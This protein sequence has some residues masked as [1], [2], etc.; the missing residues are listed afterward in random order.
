MLNI[1][2]NLS[3]QLTKIP[4]GEKGP[5]HKNWNVTPT[6][7]ETLSSNNT[8]IGLLHSLSFTCCF[9]IDNL[10]QALKIPGFEKIIDKG[11]K[12][13]SGRPNRVK[14]LYRIPKKHDITLFR[15]WKLSYKGVDVGQF[16]CIADTGYSTQDVLPPSKHPDGYTYK[17]IDKLPLTFEEIPALPKSVIKH[18]KKMK[19]VQKTFKKRYMS[20]HLSFYVKVY[21]EWY[22]KTGKTLDDD[23]MK[24]KT[25]TDLGMG[26]YLRKGSI[27]KQSLI[28]VRDEHGQYGYNFS[29]T[30]GK[31]LLKYGGFDPYELLVLKMGGET[32]ARKFVTIDD[33]ELKQLCDASNRRVVK[34]DSGEQLHILRKEGILFDKDKGF[35]YLQLD[36]MCPG[37]TLVK[38]K[39]LFTK[40]AST[41]NFSRIVKSVLYHQ[42]GVYNPDMAFWYSLVLIDFLAG[43]G[44]ESLN[45]NRTAPLY[46]FTAGDSSDGKSATIQ[47]G[48]KHLLDV[49]G[50]GNISE[51]D[52]KYSVKDNDDKEMNPIY[53]ASFEN[54]EIIKNVGS[55]QGVEDLITIKL[56][57]GC[58]ILFTQ[59]EY[60]LSDKGTMDSAGKA[61]RSMLLSYRTLSRYEAIEPR[62]L[63]QTQAGGAQKKRHQTYCVHF[64]YFTAA[65]NETLKGVIKDS[66]VGMGYTQRFI[67]GVSRSPFFNSRRKVFGSNMADS[68][69]SK[70]V[71]S[72]LRKIVYNSNRYTGYER[73]EKGFTVRIDQDAFEYLGTL[74]DMCITSTD[75]KLKKLVENVQPVARARAIVESP[76]SPIVTLEIVKWAHSVCSCGIMY[77]EWLVGQ[78]SRTIVS[79]DLLVEEK[80]EEV[81]KRKDAYTNKTALDRRTIL[82]GCSFSRMGVTARMYGDI[83]ESLIRVGVIRVYKHKSG[84]GKIL[85]KYYLAVE[86]EE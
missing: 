63:A 8:N 2:E 40:D 29:D 76:G 34:L 39:L 86:V 78:L 67:G 24:L 30:S 4:V 68:R 65:T 82:N 16:R 3:L 69:I 44:F 43:C 6:P 25:Y 14:V 77:F 38:G 7:Y 41:S 81:M 17:W 72:L 12:Y 1:Y 37:D 56:D 5:T 42:E 45:S 57:H 73:S 22:H 51:N 84:S 18:I 62:A 70:K 53:S 79:L 83:W 35:P 36:T 19:S 9:D 85:S 71:R 20:D 32:A 61:M 64:N 11:I 47:S 15:T 33:P 27:N 60:G 55:A 74:S 58:D 75:V 23:I 80:I 28:T 26:R 21:N 59:D 54:K 46:V 50:K 31:G 10:T 66:E 48:E 49:G 52:L 13:T